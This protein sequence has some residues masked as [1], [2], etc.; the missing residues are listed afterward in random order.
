[1]VSRLKWIPHASIAPSLGR[2]GASVADAEQP[3]ND[4]H[5]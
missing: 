5:D 3:Q 4:Q 1:M 2:C